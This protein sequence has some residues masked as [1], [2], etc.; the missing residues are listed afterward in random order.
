M[1]LISIGHTRNICS[2]QTFGHPNQL[3]KFQNMIVMVL[4]LN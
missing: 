3:Y 4:H 2:V 1:N